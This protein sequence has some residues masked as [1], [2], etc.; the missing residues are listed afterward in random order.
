MV[1]EAY[2]SVAERAVQ[3]DYNVCWHGAGARLAK[4][5]SA[6]LLRHFEASGHH[7]R[8]QPR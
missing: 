7:N 8:G 2:R 1:K 4:L 5:W 6:P 3:H